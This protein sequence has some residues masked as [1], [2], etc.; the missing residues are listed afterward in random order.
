MSTSMF[1]FSIYTLICLISPSL[2]LLYNSTDDVI[3]LDN[4]TF[5]Q[6][7]LGS[8]FAWNV[9]FYNSWCGHCIHFAPTYKKVAADTKGWK[10]AIGVAAIDCSDVKNQAICTHYE[11]KGFPTLKLIPPGAGHE[12]LGLDYYSIDQSEIEI[13]M[14]DYLTNLTIVNRKPRGCPYLLPLRHIENIWQSA[15]QEHKLVALIFEEEESYLGRQVILDLS[16]NSNILVLRMDAQSTKKFGI[17]TFPSL[18]LFEPHGF[19]QIAKGYTDR[20]SFVSALTALVS[21][22]KLG[23]RNQQPLPLPDSEHLQQE[24]DVLQPQNQKKSVQDMAIKEKNPEKYAV[25]MQ[26]LESA[27]TYCLRHEVAIHKDIQ[28][29]DLKAL[30]HFVRILAKYFPGRE[31]V[32]SFLRKLSSWLDGVPDITS[33]HWSHMIES[34]QT[35]DSFLPE[36]VL[37]VSCQGSQTYFRG[38]PCGMWTLFHT[39]TVNSYLYGKD[40]AKFLYKDV[41]IAIGG[42]MKHFFG[43]VFCSRHFTKMA[44]TI[45]TEVTSP[46]E[47]VLWLWRSHNKVNK[48]L[49]GDA[50]EDPKHP[51]VPFPPKS[52][53]SK[54]HKS[55][56]NQDPEFDEEAVLIYLL[57]LYGSDHIISIPNEVEDIPDISSDK[58]DMDWWQKMQRSK[59]LEKLRELRQ[60]KQEEKRKKLL[61]RQPSHRKGSSREVNLPAVGTVSTTDMGLCAVYYVLCV[62]III[63]LYYHF[64]YKRRCKSKKHF[65]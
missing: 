21:T 29:E 28:G 17:T 52:A 33:Y 1:C 44:A 40:S 25:H 45:D 42:Y 35:V 55:Q 7:I 56:G 60:Q 6:T 32:S 65:I 57:E 5:Y 48:R 37:W 51:K 64:F 22:E 41:L 49:H 20:A 4:A 14:I 58:K 53:C 31:E 23:G 12:D 30:Q 2:A 10:G 3:G 24:V 39:L 19:K 26:D 15:R 61:S 27:L 38:Y 9:E 18:Y 13:M 54:C 36:S 43:C 47:L 16:L 62:S 8:H 50:S 63:A 11:V 46:K 59:D 34:L